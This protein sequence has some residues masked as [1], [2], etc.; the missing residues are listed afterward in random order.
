MINNTHTNNDKPLIMKQRTCKKSKIAPW[1]AVKNLK[2]ISHKT[3]LIVML[4]LISSVPVQAADFI[5]RSQYLDYQ[6][7]KSVNEACQGRD[8]YRC[9]EIEV[10]YADSS[11]SW[12]NSIINAR[13]NELLPD[14]ESSN[15]TAKSNTD[16]ASNDNLVR[17]RLDRFARSQ[18]EDIPAGSSLNYSFQ[19]EPTYW[20]HVGN[21]ELFE[22]GS[23]LYLAGA[24]GMPYSEYLMLDNQTKQQI[25]LN[26]IIVSGKKQPLQAKVYQAYKAWVK[27]NNDNVASYEQMWPFE[28]TDNVLL[29]DEGLVF[30][31]QAYQISPFAYGLPELMIPYSD[32][33]GLIAPKYLPKTHNSNIQNTK[34]L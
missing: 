2:K 31:Y 12:V 18:L 15:D 24:H 22:I 13:I 10:Q 5:F 11:Q 21:I 1:A 29:T 26:D 23:Y 34:R 8:D 30:K 19:I 4:G 25:K 6:L 3:A 32:L 27:K 28:L 9:P 17:Q 20:G 14:S 7:P 33:E 16:K